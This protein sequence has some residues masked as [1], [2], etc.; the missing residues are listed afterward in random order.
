M[1]LNINNTPDPLKLVKITKDNYPG[2][3]NFI[4]YNLFVNQTSDINEEYK[5]LL[6]SRLVDASGNPSPTNIYQQVYVDFDRSKMFINKDLLEEEYKKYAD[7]CESL[8]NVNTIK[9][10]REELQ[11]I[12][13]QIS[14]LNN[15]NQLEA[16]FNGGEDIRCFIPFMYS[17][18][19]KYGIKDNSKI[20]EYMTFLQQGSMARITGLIFRMYLKSN[21]YLG[22]FFISN[23]P[24]DTNKINSS[25]FSGEKLDGTMNVKETINEDTNK[26]NTNKMNTIEAE[27]SLFTSYATK[28]RGDPY[29]FSAIN[30]ITYIDYSVNKVYLLIKNPIW[31]NESV[32]KAYDLIEQIDTSVEINK[33]IMGYIY[34]TIFKQYDNPE[35]QPLLV[36][37]YSR[38][39]TEITDTD[40]RTDIYIYGSLENFITSILNEPNEDVTIKVLTEFNDLLKTYQSFK[41]SMMQSMEMYNASRFK[42]LQLWLKQVIQTSYNKTLS[43][44]PE[45]EQTSTELGKSAIVWVNKVDE[46]ANKNSIAEAQAAVEQIQKIVSNLDALAKLYDEKTNTN[47]IKP[48]DPRFENFNHVKNTIN[49][50][51]KL[52]VAALNVALSIVIFCAIRQSNGIGNRV[53]VVDSVLKAALDSVRQVGAQVQ[54]GGA[55]N[56]D[57]L[58]QA[59]TKAKDLYD[60]AMALLN[61][62][63]EVM[64]EAA[65]SN[66]VIFNDRSILANT[67]TIL[68]NTKIPGKRILK[69]DP[70]MTIPG[71]NSSYVCFDP[72]VKLK[73]SIVNNV[74]PT[75]PIQYGGMFP[76]TQTATTSAAQSDEI[77]MQFFRRNE[78]NSLLL[79]TMNE[80]PQEIYGLK[81]AKDMGITDNNIQVTLDTLFKH[82]NVMYVEGA[83]YT[84]NLYD[85][86]YGDWQ[87]DTRPNINLPQ[88]QMPIITSYGVIIPNRSNIAMFEKEAKRERDTI[89]A[90]AQK[91]DA[92]ESGSKIRKA[93]RSVL[94]PVT[95]NVKVNVTPNDIVKPISTWALTELL[96][97]QKRNNKP[98]PLSVPVVVPGPA[99]GPAPVQTPTDSQFKSVVVPAPAPAPAPAPVT[100]TT[101]L[102]LVSTP[103]SVALPAPAPTTELSLVSTPE[104][105]LV[106]APTT[107]LV[108]APTSAVV[109]VPTSALVQAPTTALVQAPTTA[110]VQAPTSAVVQSPT[111]T[112]TSGPAPG[113]EPGSTAPERE[114][115]HVSDPERVP[116]PERVPKRPS[117]SEEAT[118][119][120]RPRRVLADTGFNTPP[121]S[122]RT[123][124]APTTGESTASTLT[125]N[126][127]NLMNSNSDGST[128]GESSASTLTFPNIITTTSSGYT[129][130]DETATNSTP[131]KTTSGNTSDE[132]TDFGSTSGESD[133][134]ASLVNN[135]QASRRMKT[136]TPIK[137]ID[138]RAATPLPTP[139]AQQNIN[140]FVEDKTS[141]RRAD[142]EDT[143]VDASPAYPRYKR[144]RTGGQSG[145]GGDLPDELIKA[146]KENNIN[147]VKDALQMKTSLVN[148]KDEYGTT[149]LMY[150]CDDQVLDIVRLLID[151][152]AADVNL[153]D[154]DGETA[155]HLASSGD[156]L[157]IVKLLLDKGA[158]VNQANNIGNTPLNIAATNSNNIEIIRI[159]LEKGAKVNHLDNLGDI[160]LANACDRKNE[161]VDIVQLLL[162]KGGNIQFINQKNNKTLLHYATQKG[163]FNIVK[164]LLEKGAQSL[165]N[166]QDEYGNTPLHIACKNGD[167]DIALLL[168]KYNA[169]ATIQNKA[170]KTPL[171]VCK[172]NQL[173]IDLITNIV[174][175]DLPKSTSNRNADVV[176]NDNDDSIKKS[177]SYYLKDPQKTEAKN[178]YYVVVD[179][180]LHPGTSISTTQKLR[181]Q[182]ARVF[183]NI[184]EARADIKGVDYVPQEMTIPEAVP[185][186]PAIIPI[187]SA[188]TRT[189]K[190]ANRIKGGRTKQ[191]KNKGRKSKQTRKN[192]RVKRRRNSRRRAKK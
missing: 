129:T 4:G 184:Q 15:K 119:S 104:S 57:P 138:S 52:A 54:T 137:E 134:E 97:Q 82:G 94:S 161:K 34:E 43:M 77:C 187:P 92:L 109:Q 154:T 181:M 180:D 183:D 179:L 98:A 84:I 59:D 12:H 96:E 114:P 36:Y 143:S 88:L 103:E 39:L 95:Q 150:A 72:R 177:L 58:K 6:G 108:Q 159:L 49:H 101:D 70:K 144:I 105:A 23:T 140:N 173:C 112:P 192:T 172:T 176:V 116:E 5:T 130:E 160:P 121:S 56:N 90:D 48:D 67:L 9:K 33:R 65:K 41:E 174:K 30:A 1:A 32:H 40:E 166:H 125:N 106:Q 189:R 45:D 142:T 93:I 89:P 35:V 118:D 55:D 17:I 69:Y 7:K 53:D 74:Q 122:P 21:D 10:F 91:G 148:A 60:I 151:N 167:E 76:F 16:V 186:P 31:C 152:Y 2:L 61:M 178:S 50:N 145:G 123:S 62:N 124:T 99:S 158:K 190:N 75:A 46:W 169:N 86:V 64:E 185:I 14:L 8:K 71:V 83:P 79:R 147:V 29:I 126:T 20:L 149:L 117:G 127:H 22:D 25:Y 85:W 51:A 163:F 110:L 80:S 107:A 157:D 44:S 78:F 27:V 28:N 113:L 191:R 19:N 63:A 162:S 153:V 165:I 73:Q 156:N 81:D 136:L 102:S 115:E 128:T 87:I 3:D 164:L 141:K 26:M 47:T 139:K 155:L 66:P 100:S 13:D 168:L 182:C 171:N 175:R 68:M 135:Q 111:S 24:P 11:Q 188:K 120:K 42:Q 37:I 131:A 133:S 38:F 132:E 170:G 146:V 18:Y